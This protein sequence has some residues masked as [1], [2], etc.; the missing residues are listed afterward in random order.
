MSLGFH[1]FAELLNFDGLLREYE[2]IFAAAVVVEHVHPMRVC[3]SG[4]V[5]F[6]GVA[7]LVHVGH[8]FVHIEFYALFVFSQV[9]A[10]NFYLNNSLKIP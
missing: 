5:H 9:D 10:S 7:L 3:E 1:N 6:E 2:H 4:F 8:E